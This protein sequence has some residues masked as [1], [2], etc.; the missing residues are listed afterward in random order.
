MN[1]GLAQIVGRRIAGVV[2]AY[3]PRAPRQQVF[4]MFDDGTRFEFWGDDFSCC[5][6]VTK[7]GG[8]AEYVEMVGGKIVERYGALGISVKKR[9]EE[10]R[11]RRLATNAIEKAK[12][13][14]TS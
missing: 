8:L 14:K 10:I 13:D 4:L 6:G 2:V 5:R 12:G 3:G 9:A 7:A 11:S 1:T